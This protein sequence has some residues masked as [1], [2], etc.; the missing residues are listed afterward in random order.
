MKGPILYTQTDCAE[1][2]A[3]SHQVKAWLIQ[4]GVQFTECNVTG[5]IDAARALYATSVF[6][7]PLLLIGDLKVLGFRTRELV[8]ILGVALPSA[9]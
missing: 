5:D 3:A 1:S 2:A 7:T 9:A 4:H 8:K 6:A